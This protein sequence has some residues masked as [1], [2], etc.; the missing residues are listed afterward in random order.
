M[1]YNNYLVDKIQYTQNQDDLVFNLYKGVNDLIDITN[2]KKNGILFNGETSSCEQWYLNTPGSEP[3]PV[4]TIVVDC[5]ALPNTGTI[6]IP[7]NI[8][9]ITGWKIISFDGTATDPTL[10][11]TISM[12]SNTINIIITSI[13][14]CIT[15]TANLSA[16]TESHLIIKYI[17]N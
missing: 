15:T 17:K 13:N 3:K 1:D 4:F 11:H 7:H 5:G 12:K 10:L 9:I 6:V 8:P 2:I 16:F 14:I